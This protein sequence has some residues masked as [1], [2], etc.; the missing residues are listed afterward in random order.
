MNILGVH[1]RVPALG[2]I[3]AG[4]CLAEHMVLWV[5]ELV[6]VSECKGDGLHTTKTFLV[7]CAC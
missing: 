6:F 1:F 5:E 4:G 3:P 2:L 7:L